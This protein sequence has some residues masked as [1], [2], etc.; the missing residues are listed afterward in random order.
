LN[1]FNTKSSLTLLYERRELKTKDEI[2]AAADL[3]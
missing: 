2:A 3:G 1:G